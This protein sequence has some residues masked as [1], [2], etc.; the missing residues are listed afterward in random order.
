MIEHRLIEK[1]LKAAAKLADA[2][3]Q[4]TYDPVVVDSIVDFIKTYADRTHHGKEEDIL[5]Q[6]LSA[7]NVSGNDLKVMN[8]LIDEHKQARE[9]VKT[10][11]ELNERYKSGD[12]KV[13][14]QIKEI[15]LWLAAFYPVHIEKEDKEFFP[16]SE[17]YF[18]T[19]ELEAMIEDFWKFDRNMIHEKYQNILRSISR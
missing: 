16:K 17:K 5:F 15:I 4:T 10:I 18:N 19:A 14:L 6:E 2:L 8:E 12:K 9:K 7:K 1:L 3:T 11:V 13:V